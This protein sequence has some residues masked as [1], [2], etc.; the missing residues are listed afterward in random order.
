MAFF[1]PVF[2]GLEFDGADFAFVSCFGAVDFV[3]PAGAAVSALVAEALGAN[4]FGVPG[5]AGVAGIARA[6]GADW[7]ACA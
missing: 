7:R 5:V 3:D 6:A 1:G 4:A 2:F